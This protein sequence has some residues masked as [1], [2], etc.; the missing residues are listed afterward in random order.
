MRVEVLE[1]KRFTPQISSIINVHAKVKKMQITRRA[2][3]LGLTASVAALSTAPAFAAPRPSL[4]DPYW[5]QSGSGADV[6]HSGWAS[7]L[8]RYVRP[9]ADGVNLVAYGSVS[10]ADKSALKQYIANLTATDP[11]GLTR[12]A[13]MAYWFNLYNAETVNVILDEYPVDS[14]KKVGGGFFNTGPWDN[15]TMTVAGR[16]LSLNDVEH[17]I[18]RPIWNDPRIHYGVNCASIGCPNLMTQPFTASTLN[19]MLDEAARTFIN[20][21]RGAS[22]VNGRLVVSSIFEWFKVDFG[23]NDAGVINHLRQ[24]ASGP[25]AGQLANVSSISDDEYDWALNGV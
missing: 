16:S 10:G 11:T 4:V 6:D 2:A 20:H 3:I 19:P 13:Q 22:V 1:R 8:G 15:K 25:L 14:I 24:Y 9:S 18:L 7:F 23:N 12:D 21:P 5:Q 17:G